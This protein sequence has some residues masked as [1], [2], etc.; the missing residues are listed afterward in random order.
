M[1]DQGEKGSA[2]QAEKEVNGDQRT[3]WHPL[4]TGLI[5]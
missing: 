1:E 3:I 5:T 4:K 2:N